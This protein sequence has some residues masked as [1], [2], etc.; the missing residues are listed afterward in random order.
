MFTKEIVQCPFC[1]KTFEELSSDSVE[2]LIIHISRRHLEKYK[3]IEKEASLCSQSPYY[4]KKPKFEQ[5][6]HHVFENAR[7]GGCGR[8]K[9][10]VK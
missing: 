7:H 5:A 8:C 3:K 2:R 1:E 6:F 4:G 10:A 9:H